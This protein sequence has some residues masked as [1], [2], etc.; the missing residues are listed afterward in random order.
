MKNRKSFLMALLL[1][2]YLGII[3]QGPTTFSN[4]QDDKD[5]EDIV[6]LLSASNSVVIEWN[7][8]WGGI[9]E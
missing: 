3:V 1:M 6:P 8:T 5:N 4:E 7:R 2:L 9:I